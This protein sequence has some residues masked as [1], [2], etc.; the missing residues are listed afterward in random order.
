MNKK[1]KSLKKSAVCWRQFTRHNDAIFLSLGKEIRIGVL[2]VATLAFATPDSAAAMM[3]MEH[4]ADAA[5]CADEEG[6]TDSLS[7]DM[8]LDL[9]NA[10]VVGTPTRR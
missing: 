3:S 6:L 4:P 7:V 5:V 9:Q 8:E 10:E 2:S 1:E